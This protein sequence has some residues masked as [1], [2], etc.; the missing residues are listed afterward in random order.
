MKTAWM[1]W[2]AVM[3]AAMIPPGCS[4]VEIDPQPAGCPTAAPKAGETCSVAA[5][6]CAYTAGPCDV[7]LSC[8]AANDV[9][10]SATKSCLPA[11]KECW[12]AQEGDVCAIVLA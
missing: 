12:S 7:E 5:A 4:S 9:W 3:A 2:A 11:A 10:T 6:G 1:A 8:K